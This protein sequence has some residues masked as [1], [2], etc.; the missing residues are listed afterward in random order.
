MRDAA[1][2]YVSSFSD[3]CESAVVNSFHVGSAGSRSHRQATW[4][5]MLAVRRILF[6]WAAMKC[7]GDLPARTIAAVS[8]WLESGE[9]TEWSQ[10]STPAPA[11]RYGEVIVDCD[12]SRG[13]PIAN[14]A[15][16]T[17]RFANAASVTDAI[18]VLESVWLADNDGIHC[19]NSMRLEEWIVNVALPAA[20]EFR[21]LSETELQQ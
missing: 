4:L 2:S 1:F 12:A 18:E 11:V 9:M 8:D 13:E 19:V 17:A 3:D 21:Y 7:E 10:Y 20:I 14:A 5:C 6:G 16:A 15:A